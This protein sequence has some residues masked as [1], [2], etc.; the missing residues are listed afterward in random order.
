MT[1]HNHINREGR[2]DTMFAQLLPYPFGDLLVRGSY[3]TTLCVARNPSVRGLFP[4]T[5]F[6]PGWFAT[7]RPVHPE[8]SNLYVLNYVVLNWI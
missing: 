6:P 2:W 8:A 5:A 1:Q 4:Q 3:G 7:V